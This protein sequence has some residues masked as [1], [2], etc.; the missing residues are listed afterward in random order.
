MQTLG[1]CIWTI[2]STHPKQRLKPTFLAIWYFL[3]ILGKTILV[4]LTPCCC[5]SHREILTLLTSSVRTELTAIS[6]TLLHS[7]KTHFS[8]TCI[9][10]QP[11]SMRE[12]E[13]GQKTTHNKTNCRGENPS[14]FS[15][16]HCL[17]SFSFEEQAVC[18]RLSLF[19]SASFWL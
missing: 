4:L 11:L 13:W 14:L 8:C 1:H 17:F 16:L 3:Y 19:F 7:R 12:T 15:A 5:S 10:F 9:T 18:N 6:V 2:I